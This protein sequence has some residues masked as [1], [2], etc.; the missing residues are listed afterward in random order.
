MPLDGL[1]AWI[2][3]VERKLGMRTRV[4]LVLATIA[5]GGAGA[6]I[7]LALD[8]RDTAVSESDVRTLQEDLEAQIASDGT[9]A[10]G[11]GLP[12]LEADLRT[13]EG[14]VE[15]LRDG[16]A[17]ATEEKAADDE[18]DTGAPAP[19]GDPEASGAAAGPEGAGA[20]TGGESAVPP[21]GSVSVDGL[22]KERQRELVEEA[23]EHEAE[24]K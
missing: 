24:T 3:E 4:F 10:T 23:A 18:T 20:S 11:S 1:R 2:G 16:Q 8:T 15:R 22:S 17:T 5:I 12:E 6:A 9:T 13:L 14:K 19:G 21:P 7:Y